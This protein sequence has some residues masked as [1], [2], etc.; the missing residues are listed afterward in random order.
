MNISLFFSRTNP[1]LTPAG[2][3]TATT[4]DACPPR[5]A[6]TSSNSPSVKATRFKPLSNAAKV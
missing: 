3:L 6:V 2:A 4:A 1:R 5:N